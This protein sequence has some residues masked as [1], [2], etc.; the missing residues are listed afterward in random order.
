MA[1]PGFLSAAEYL[2]AERT[3]LDKHEYADG[4]ITAMARATRQPVT[5]S[6]NL[7]GIMY[8]ILS[9]TGCRPMNSGM[10]VGT[11]DDRLY[12]Y[13]DLTIVCGEPEFKDDAFDTL[14]NP[15]IIFEVLSPATE[16][17]D[18]GLKFKRY[19]EIPSL[20]E[21]V[22]VSSEEPTVEVFTRDEGDQWTVHF[23]DGLDTQVALSAVP[24]E[25]PMREVFQ[26]VKF[27]PEAVPAAQDSSL[28]A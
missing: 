17:H 8:R 6:T 27:E 15:V 23:Y 7:T 3:A 20:R 9:G 19:R 5:I 25:V 18:R 2:A 21:Y 22:L 24:V 10:R 4:V 16:R 14:L 12:T 28:R 11:P 1:A 26:D 13:P